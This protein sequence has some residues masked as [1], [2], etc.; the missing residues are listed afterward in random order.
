MKNLN[1]LSIWFDKANKIFEE[2]KD[3]D[4]VIIL[5][6]Q[7]A[8]IFIFEIRLP[9]VKDED[10]II[11][12]IRQSNEL[13]I[14]YIICFWNNGSIDV[15]SFSLRKKILALSEYNNNTKI[16]LYHG[17]KIIGKKIPEIF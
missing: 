10:D 8:N 9:G 17:E 3:L 16:I 11:R 12:Q 14:D 7:K 15:P 13:D 2:K 5:K 1:D 6:T 4:Q